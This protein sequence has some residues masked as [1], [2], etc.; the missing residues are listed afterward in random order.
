MMRYETFLVK[1]VWY[2]KL[3]PDLFRPDCSCM[4]HSRTKIFGSMIVFMSIYPVL[5]LLTSPVKCKIT[6]FCPLLY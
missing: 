2:R 5:F 3:W 1:D 6:H 4:K